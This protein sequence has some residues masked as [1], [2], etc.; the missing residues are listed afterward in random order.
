MCIVEGAF[1]QPEA[2]ILTSIESTDAEPHPILLDSSGTRVVHTVQVNNCSAVSARSKSGRAILLLDSAMVDVGPNDLSPQG[3]A[4]AWSIDECGAGR[5]RVV[6]LGD[7]GFIGE[8]GVPGSGPGLM[9][10][11][12]NEVFV[13]QVV[14]WLLS[15]L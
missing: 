1:R 8:P 13:Q 2:G 4:F 12:Q 15:R 7:S 6:I 3:E 10:K 5:G 11:G 14:M 9:D